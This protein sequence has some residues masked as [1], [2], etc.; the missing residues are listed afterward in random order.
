MADE[1]VKTKTQLDGIDEQEEQ[2]IKNAVTKSKGSFA[3]RLFNKGA[4]AG[5]NLVKGAA[6]AGTKVAAGGLA[7]VQS[8]SATSLAVVLSTVLG[9][10]SG[11]TGGDDYPVAYR[12]DAS[13][14]VY[15]CV[16]HYSEAYAGLFG[17]LDDQ[18]LPDQNNNV[19]L[20]LK[21]INEWS[22]ATKSGMLPAMFTARMFPAS[23]AEHTIRA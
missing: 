17:S 22:K 7:A 9:L 19:L 11:M 15:Q 8:V 14:D 3:S 23:H 10:T 16:D 5:A 2:A 18:P 6:D 1:Y 4:N 12:D 20:R 21:E 13:D